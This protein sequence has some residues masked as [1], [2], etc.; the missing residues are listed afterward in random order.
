METVIEYLRQIGTEIERKN[1]INSK[2]YI[3][4]KTGKVCIT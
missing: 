4:Y 1:I 2:Q 3:Q